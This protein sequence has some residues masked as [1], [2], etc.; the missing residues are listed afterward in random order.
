MNKTIQSFFLLFVGLLSIV[1]AQEISDTKFG[2][3]MINFIAKDS[4]FSVKFAPRIQ[5]RFQ[6][7]WD[8][9]EEEYD[10]AELNFL[11]RRARLKFGGFA[12]TP[13][14][15]YK[16]ELGLSN[17]DLSGASVYN[18]NT[19]R[20]IL[21][22]VV[23]WN[24]HENFELWAGQTKLPG[25]IERVV[26]SANLQLIDR[27]LLNSKF[28]IDRDMG[29]QLRHKTKLG[30]NWISREK[31]SISQ[32]EG[33][34]ITEGNIGG[35]QYTSRLELL[36]FGEFSSKGDYSQGDLKREK[37]IKAMFGFTYD[38]NNNAVK[39]RSN[40]GSYMTQSNGGLFET[41][42][43]T[44]FID[45]VIKYNGFALTGEY[46]SRNADTIEALEADGRTKTGAVVGA[47][48]AINFQGSYLFKNN[49]EM[50]LRYT[51][52]DFKEVTRLSDLQQITYGISKYVV[53]H[54]LKIQADLS[55]SQSSSMRDFVLFR[56]GFDLHF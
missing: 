38:I 51:N 31:F 32:G 4:S 16:I 3:G 12:F 44:V 13:K 54:S 26:S 22:A 15:K 40:M 6:S 39:N 41:D 25:N 56:T 11:V 45:G 42:I 2:K 33:R 27:S 8:Y 7:Q 55:F 18:R 30:G 17:R 1:Q 10:D 36:P 20:Y 48:S 21:D 35:L 14:L 46:A 34:N 43:T 19:P 23:M 52:V 37:S 24:F 53:G 5:S 9:N 47:G 28:N 50:T 29:I 49:V